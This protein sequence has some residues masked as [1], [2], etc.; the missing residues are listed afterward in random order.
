MIISNNTK[1]DWSE[2]LAQLYEI[3]LYKKENIIAIQEK[4]GIGS[5]ANQI[6]VHLKPI[7]KVNSADKNI[8]YKKLKT[9]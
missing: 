6:A 1:T 2:T 5:N 9:L 8:Y 7:L 3:F 4:L